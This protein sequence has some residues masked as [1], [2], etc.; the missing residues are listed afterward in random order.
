MG[1]NHR[2]VKTREIIKDLT[3]Q[4]VHNLE[5]YTLPDMVCASEKKFGVWLDKQ[6]IYDRLAQEYIETIVLGAEDV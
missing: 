6:V 1:M 3:I 2:A 4:E 5:K